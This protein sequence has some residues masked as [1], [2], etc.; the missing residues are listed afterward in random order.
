MHGGH[1][2][3]EYSAT[4]FDATVM[5]PNIDIYLTRAR[6]RAHTDNSLG[7]RVNCAD[8][9]SAVR[10]RIVSVPPVRTDKSI[11]DRNVMRKSMPA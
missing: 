4:D 3:L 10:R 2:I 7:E 8:L 11:L 5:V 1:D 6:A 9:C